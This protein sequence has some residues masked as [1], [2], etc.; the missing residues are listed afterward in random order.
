MVDWIANLVG[1]LVA[2]IGIPKSWGVNGTTSVIYVVCLVVPLLIVVA[3]TTYAER[4]V[5]GFIQGRLGPNRVGPKGLLQPFADLL[6][7]L[8]K[9]II[10]PSNA[11]RYLFIIAPLLT[12]VPSLAAWAVLP[13]SSGAVLADDVIGC[14]RCHRRRMGIEFQICIP[15]RHAL[16]CTNRGL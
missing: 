1:T 2:F 8:C 10:V 14:V 16:R 5:I 4:K 7:L 11:N 6:K 13:V 3:Y 15:R 12:L 9:E